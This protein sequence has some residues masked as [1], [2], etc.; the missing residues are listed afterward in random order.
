[1]RIHYVGLGKMGIAMVERL[2]A[3]RYRV[4]AFDIDEGAR[5]GAE[6]AGADVVEN[7]EELLGGCECARRHC[8]GDGCTVEREH[9]YCRCKQNARKRGRVIWLMVPDGVVEE[10]VK[11]MLPYLHK[12]DIVI[13]GGNGKY[14]NVEDYTRRVGRKGAEWLDVGVSGGPMGA[15]NG[16]C[17]LIG[18][19]KKVYQTLE[20]LFRDLSAVD[21]YLYVGPSGAGHFVKMVH[22]AIEYGMMQSIAEGFD[23]LR[24]APYHLSLKDIAQV[25]SH[26]SVIDSALMDHTAGAFEQFGDALGRVTGHAHESG[27]GKWFAKEA[28]TLGLSVPVIKAS[29]RARFATRKNPSF[30]GRVISALRHRF[31]GHSYRDV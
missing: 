17:L 14:R 19:K 18:G 6:M 23:V 11:Q 24:N 31:G 22:N 10:V 4:T 7:F 29:V 30:Q 3:K 25:Y 8:G 28:E 5:K 1:M 20:G 21:G 27:M 15:R 13:D 2:I 9:T 12:G 26:G 16:T